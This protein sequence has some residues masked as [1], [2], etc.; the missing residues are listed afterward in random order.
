MIIGLFVSFVACTDLFF[1]SGY[2]LYVMGYDTNDKASMRSGLV[3]SHYLLLKMHRESRD[4]LPKS[5]ASFA[6]ANEAK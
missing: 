5:L 1:Q 2:A 4:G 6:Q 3:F